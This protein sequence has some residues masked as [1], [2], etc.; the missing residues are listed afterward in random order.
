MGLGWFMLSA[1]TFWAPL[2]PGPGAAMRMR[3]GDREGWPVN[4]VPAPMAELTWSSSRV[5]PGRPLSRRPRATA[6]ADECLTEARVHPRHRPRG[7]AAENF[8]CDTGTDINIKNRQDVDEMDDTV[9]TN[10]S[11]ESFAGLSLLRLVNEAIVRSGSA[12]HAG[13]FSQRI[14]SVVGARPQK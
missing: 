9:R 8:C 5:T 4:V 3:G 1:G 2:P 10:Q 7:G 13:N 14:I 11:G 12:K 6:C